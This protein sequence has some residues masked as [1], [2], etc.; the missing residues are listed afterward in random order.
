M[1]LFGESCLV[2]FVWCVCVCVGQTCV[3][4]CCLGKCVLVNLGEFGVGKCCS[5]RFV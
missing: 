1:L 2:S 5:V 3:G 4:K